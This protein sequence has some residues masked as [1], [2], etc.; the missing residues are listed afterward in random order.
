[1]SAHTPGP[2]V[3]GAGALIQDW[4]ADSQ[5]RHIASVTRGFPTCSVRADRTGGE[6]V[7]AE[8]DANAR[9][10]AA[11]PEL[12]LALKGAHQATD[13][14]LAMLIERDPTFLPTKSGVWHLIEGA[15]AVIKKAEGRS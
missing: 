4:V 8:A 6:V 13:Q 15:N 1:M 11:A 2:W 3:T 9:L 7:D 12:L 14:L 10:I 5:G